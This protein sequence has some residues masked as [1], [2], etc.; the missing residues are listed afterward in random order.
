MDFDQAFDN[1]HR[2]AKEYGFDL[3]MPDECAE[4]VRALVDE[5]QDDPDQ[6]SLWFEQKAKALF[7]CF[8]ARPRWLQG[9]EW[10]VHD[11]MP[12][13]FVGQLDVPRGVHAGSFQAHDAAYYVFRHDRTGETRVIVQAD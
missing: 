2:I 7:R 11:R 5:Y 13:T 9:P 1:A 10:P 12:F 4:L 6:F 8:D 3:D